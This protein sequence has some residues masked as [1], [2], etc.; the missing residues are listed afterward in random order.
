ML[1]ARVRSR[2]PQTQMPPLGTQLRD[3]EALALLERWI[4]EKSHTHPEELSHESTDPDAKL[5]RACLAR[6]RRLPSL[7]THR[8][9]CADDKLARGKYL[10]TVAGCNDCHTPWKTGPAGPEPDMSRMLSGHP[11][12]FPITAPATTP[13]GPWLWSPLRRRTR[14]FRVRGA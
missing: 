11:E 3:A 12:S 10:V 14:R 2:N 5:A 4:A 6:A 8:G 1:I 13:A 7:A 9:L